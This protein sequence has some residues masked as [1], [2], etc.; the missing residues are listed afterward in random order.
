MTSERIK[1]IQLETAYPNSVSVQQALL[2]VWNECEQE[3]NKK[4]YLGCN[5]K[6]EKCQKI[7]LDYAQKNNIN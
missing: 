5:R 4:A 7:L 6:L 1:E 3:K 2:K